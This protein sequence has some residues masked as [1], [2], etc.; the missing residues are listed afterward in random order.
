MSARVIHRRI[1]MCRQ[2][3][4]CEVK[5]E[6]N[7]AYNGMSAEFTFLAQIMAEFAMLVGQLLVLAYQ[8][9]IHVPAC[10][11]HALQKC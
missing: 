11:V 9:M 10:V 7:P 8:F 5:E 6:G 2:E 3:R 4:Y 1:K